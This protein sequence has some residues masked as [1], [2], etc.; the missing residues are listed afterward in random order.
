M[1]FNLGAY[2]QY[3]LAAV[4]LL[5]TYG[6]AFFLLWLSQSSRYAEFIKTFH[7]IAQNFLTVINVIFALNLA[8]LAND[9][10]DARDRALDAVYRESGS[11]NNILDLA[12]NVPDPARSN[13]TR[14]V[15]NYAR[16]TAAN[17]W[18]RLARRESSEQVSDQLDAL[19]TQ[20]SAAAGYGHNV[21][22]GQIF[23]CKRPAAVM[24][25]A[26]GQPALPPLGFAQ[27][28]GLVALPFLIL[29]PQIVGEGLDCF[30]AFHFGFIDLPISKIQNS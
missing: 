19:L 28:S 5:G 10:W 8:F 6:A 27:D 22:H 3:Y 13:I 15:E 23:R 17:E 4:V 24:A 21:I 29:G 20:V 25:S 18:P 7:G 11:L 2:D 14:V 30:L 9:T 16:L 26:L 12:R 1:S